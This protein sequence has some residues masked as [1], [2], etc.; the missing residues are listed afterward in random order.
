MSMLFEFQSIDR[1]IDIVMHEIIQNY[2]ADDLNKEQFL[3]SMEYISWI[4]SVH[5][6]RTDDSI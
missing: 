6:E 1:Y 5:I 4:E 2:G 3:N